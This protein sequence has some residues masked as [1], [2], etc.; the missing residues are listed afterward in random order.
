M[1]ILFD[2]SFEQQLDLPLA[3]TLEELPSEYPIYLEAFDPSAGGHEL[4]YESD[5][6]N[7]RGN[8]SNDISERI[9]ALWSPT[10]TWRN[11]TSLWLDI[12]HGSIHNIFAS[13]AMADI[14]SN[15]YQSSIASTVSDLSLAQSSMNRLLDLKRKVLV[16]AC[17]GYHNDKTCGSSYLCVNSPDVFEQGFYHYTHKYQ[18]SYPI[19]HLPSFDDE[20]I[21]DILLFVMCMIGISFFKTEDAVAF[22]RMAYPVRIL[23]RALF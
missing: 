3:T 2:G 15:N 9:Q 14:L 13:P 20:I 10:S 12:T 17:D 5:F 1:N 6:A 7:T 16:C 21:P 19:L 4:S 18:P 23:L 22:V 8:D 11:R